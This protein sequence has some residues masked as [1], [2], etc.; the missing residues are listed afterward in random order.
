MPFP[1]VN[2]HPHSFIEVLQDLL[3]P[4]IPENLDIRDFSRDLFT[5]IVIP[6]TQ[7]FCNYGAGSKCRW[8]DRVPVTI[9]NP[10]HRDAA[11]SADMATHDSRIITNRKHATAVF[12]HP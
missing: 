3:H 11:M 4:F 7:H 1:Q 2:N 10:K 5:Y 8:N 6:F 9:Y 12:R